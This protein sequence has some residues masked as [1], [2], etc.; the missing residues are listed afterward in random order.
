MHCWAGWTSDFCPIPDTCIDHGYMIPGANGTDVFCSNFCPA[1]CPE[2]YMQ[3]NGPTDSVTG[4]QVE[5]DYCIEAVSLILLDFKSLFAIFSVM[6][7]TLL[8]HFNLEP[9]FHNRG[10]RT[11]SR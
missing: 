5:P 8:C 11:I 10:V 9:N 6:T 4:C 7:H 1:I 2:G 3:C